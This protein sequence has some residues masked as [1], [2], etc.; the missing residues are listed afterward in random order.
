MNVIDP[1]RL[2]N[3]RTATAVAHPNIALVKY[4]GKRDAEL[5]LP[6][7]DSL[8][9]TLD[10][11]T[12]TTS[13]MLTD[14][15]DVLKLND[16]S[17]SKSEQHKLRSLADAFREASATQFGVAVT[18]D[19]NF[20]TAAGLASSAS[21]FAALV[22]ALDEAFATRLSME[23]L[24]VLARRGSG[25]APRSL[26]EGFAHM[27]RGQAADGSDAVASPVLAVNDWPLEVVVAITSE[28]AKSISSTDGMERTR[29]TSPFYP[30]WLES[31]Q[32]D[33]ERALAAVAAR[34]FDALAAVS[35]HSC[36]KMHGLMLSA[37]P[38]LV[39]WNDATTRCV[40]AVQSLRSSGLP[41]FFTIDAGPQIKAVCLPQATEAVAEALARTEGV[42]R[43]LKT[44]LGLGARAA[45]V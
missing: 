40:H 15:P 7:V 35:E 2:E 41:V 21:G 9:I 26:F 1:I 17:G 10:T 31:Q 25:S 36:L 28:E 39:Y 33:I 38:G 11:L 27:H 8:S 45:F 43:V 30:T 14:G 34:D 32:G 44:G 16:R 3:G 22:V 20:P 19:N 18:S 24:S 13:V 4:W 29:T 23:R 42:H 12:T 5:N 37:R 6:A